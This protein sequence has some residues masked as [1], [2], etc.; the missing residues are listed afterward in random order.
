[1]LLETPRSVDVVRLT[2]DIWMC[3][4]VEVHAIST[5]LREVVS[6]MH[7]PWTVESDSVNVI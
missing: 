5:R 7:F 3:C 1:M 6:A 2:R 4:F